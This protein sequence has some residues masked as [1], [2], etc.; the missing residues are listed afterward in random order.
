MF[1]QTRAEFLIPIEDLE[2]HV[3]RSIFLSFIRR[4][5][6]FCR[7]TQLA[8]VLCELITLIQPDTKP[9]L[10]VTGVLY[11]CVLLKFLQTRLQTVT[12]WYFFL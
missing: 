10:L 2:R 1:L 11:D 9:S 6:L 5:I 4:V 12:S 7:D 3:L 8:R